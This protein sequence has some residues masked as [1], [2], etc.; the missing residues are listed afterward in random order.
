MNTANTKIIVDLLGAD[1]PAYTLEGPWQASRADTNL[2]PVLTGDTA[3]IETAPAAKTFADRTEIIH[4]TEALSCNEQ[5]TTAIRTNPNS[6]MALSLRAL[7]ERP[8][9]G[10]VVSAGSTGAL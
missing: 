1:N 8:D 10:A 6:S 4:T 2:T 9:C 3:L 7:K 5:P